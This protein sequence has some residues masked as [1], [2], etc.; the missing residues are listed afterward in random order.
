[1]NLYAE[2]CKIR[3]GE[4]Q[5][6]IFGGKIELLALLQLPSSFFLQQLKKIRNVENPNRSSTTNLLLRREIRE[7]ERVERTL[8]RFLKNRY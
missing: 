1:L 4:T 8:R 5:Y 6:E 3:I 7:G 2:N